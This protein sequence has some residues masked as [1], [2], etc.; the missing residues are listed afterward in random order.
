MEMR[1]LGNTGIDVSRLCFGTGTDG[2]NG[3]SNQTRLGMQE[4]VDLMRYAFD[5]GITFF[6]AADQYGS[7]PNMARLLKDVGR[8]NAVIT[9]KTVARTAEEAEADIDRFC[10]EL[11]TDVL[12]I[13]LMH[14][15]M[16]AD[17]PEARAGVLEVLERKKQEGVIRAHG[18][19]CH[20]FGAFCTAAECDWVEVVL[21]RI[22]YAG[23]HMDGPPE[24]IIPVIEKMHAAGKGVY[25]MKVV[26]AGELGG[27]ARD[28]IHYVL[29]IPAIDAITIGMQNRQEVDDNIGYVGSHTGAPQPV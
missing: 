15:M 10:R 13:V 12:D 1:V 16:S 5:R 24:K 3:R 2:W 28:A 20:D 22:N 7:H 21:A 26:G 19:S 27:D 14:C 25:G 8:N 9:T 17:W 6:D 11:E 18:V 23:K 4:L 29:D